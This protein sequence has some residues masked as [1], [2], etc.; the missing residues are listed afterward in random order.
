MKLAIATKYAAIGAV[1]SIAAYASYSHMRD[2]AI[3]HGQHATVA[4]LLPVSVDGMLIVATV[5]MRED[6]QAGLKVRPWA[7][8]AFVLGVLASIVANILSAQDDIT[9]RV[10]S[11][12]PAVALLL[13]VEMLTSGRKAADQSAE[14]APLPAETPVSETDPV[15]SNVMT[16]EPVARPV[17]RAP[18]A[19]KVARVRTQNPAMPQEDVAKKAG[20]SVRTVARHWNDTTP[21]INGHD[22][23]TGQMPGQLTIN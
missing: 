16:S 8:V 1:A 20:V 19:A 7:W 9:S 3:E 22:V 2:L 12:W 15:M 13:V 14:V 23:L 10:I 17:K 18:A 21:H 11:A 5:V 6:R 4:A